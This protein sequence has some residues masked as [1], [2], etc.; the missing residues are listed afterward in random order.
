MIITLT[1]IEKLRRDPNNPRRIVTAKRQSELTASL[2]I[3]GIK[4][5]LIG[6]VVPD[7]IMVCDG[8]R[9]LESSLEVGIKEVPIVILPQKPSEG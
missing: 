5:P 3:H 1:P 6:Y 4:V 9:R 8:H 7:G 2:R